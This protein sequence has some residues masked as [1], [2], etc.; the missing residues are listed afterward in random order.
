M[1]LGV[2]PGN[3]FESRLWRD[4]RIESTGWMTGLLAQMSWVGVYQ[5]LLGGRK[6]EGGVQHTND[7]LYESN[8]SREMGKCSISPLALMLL[9]SLDV[10]ERYRLG[11]AAS[12]SIGDG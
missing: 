7:R 5:L 6:R 8:D 1:D 2:A 10:R 9:L 4:G 3:R 11:Q 12:F